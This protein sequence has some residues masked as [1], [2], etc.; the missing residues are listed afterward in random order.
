VETIDPSTIILFAAVLL[1]FPMTLVWIGVHIMGIIRL[2]S[3]LAE[4][5]GRIKLAWLLAGVG[6]FMGPCVVLA[7]LVSMGIAIAERRQPA[8]TLATQR[9]SSTILLAGVI[10]LLMAA[11]LAIAALLQ[12]LLT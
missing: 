4:L 10:I 3:S 11:E 8:A 9:A 7:S 6:G 2:G 5:S 1:A 12:V